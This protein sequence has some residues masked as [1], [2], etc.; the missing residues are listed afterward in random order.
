MAN[1]SLAAMPSGRILLAVDQYGPGVKH[2]TGTKG[3]HERQNHW[4]QGRVAVSSDKGQTWNLR[5]D[6][7]FCQPLLFRDGQSLYILGNRGP[8]QIMKSADG[9]E[10]WSGPS[11]LTDSSAGGDRFFQP[12]ANIIAANGQLTAIL[13]ILADPMHRGSPASVLIPVIFRARQGSDLSSRRSWTVTPVNKRYR[14]LFPPEAGEHLGIPFHPLPASGRGQDLGKGRWADP[15]GWDC[16]HLIHI[17]KADHCWHDPSG[18][19]LLLVGRAETHQSHFAV[20]LKALDDGAGSLSFEPVLAPSGRRWSFLHIPGGH[21][22]FRLLYDEVSGLFWLLSHR[23]SGSMTRVEC[24]PTDHRDL[25]GME[26]H[27]LHLSCS[28]NLVDWSF[29]G[30]V[31]AGANPVDMRYEATMAIR[32]ADLGVAWSDGAGF[33]RPARGANRVRFGLIPNFR[34]LAG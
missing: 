1:P 27:A 8:A 10:T 25:P 15:P 18:R 4:L 17:P 14:D 26:R 11:E 29:A 5:S 13:P 31:T 19:T 24:L 2:L 33:G 32:G 22:P 16:L 12:S 3:R 20:I 21:L 28:N 6:F 7:P 9:G 23:T 30:L 34:D